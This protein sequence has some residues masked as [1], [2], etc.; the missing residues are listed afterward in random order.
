MAAMVA[1]N[2]TNGHGGSNAFRGSGNASAEPVL[3]LLEEDDDYLKAH[4]LR[5]LNQGNNI[6]N[7]WHEVAEYVSEIEA[8]SEV[9]RRHLP[10]TAQAV[11]PRGVRRPFDDD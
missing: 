10:S 4:A 3:A 9:R 1:S 5:A 6:M 7:H 2:G 8:L 11:R